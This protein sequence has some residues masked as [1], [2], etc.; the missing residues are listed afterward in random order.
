[1]S[2]CH[3][4]LSN[5]SPDVADNTSKLISGIW[6]TGRHVGQQKGFKGLHFTT[7]NLGDCDGM[8]SALQNGS[9]SSVCPVSF[10]TMNIPTVRSHTLSLGNYS[11]P[12]ID[13]SV[14]MHKIDKNFAYAW[15]L[16]QHIGSGCH[17]NEVSCYTSVCILFVYVLSYLRRSD[18]HYHKVNPPATGM[19]SC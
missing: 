17:D 3:D 5:Q 1:M 13:T 18:V 9:S 14:N 4:N 19:T 16:V 10:F 6:K 8:L 11:N 2:I 7:G 15:D 12:T